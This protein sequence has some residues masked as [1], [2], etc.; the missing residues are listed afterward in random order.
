M[1]TENSDLAAIGSD[2]NAVNTDSKMGLF[3]SYIVTVRNEI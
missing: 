1:K 2:T 3:D